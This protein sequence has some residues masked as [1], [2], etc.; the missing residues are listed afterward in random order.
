VAP[1]LAEL[2]Q[3]QADAVHLGDALAAQPRIGVAVLLR[4][5]DRLLMGLRRGPYGGGEWSVPSG[6]LERGETPVQCAERE[7][8]EEAGIAGVAMRMLRARPS[9]GCVDAVRYSYVSTYDG[10]HPTWPDFVTLWAVGALPEPAEARVLEPEKCEA[11][12]WVTRE[13]LPTP[14]FRCFASLLRAGV[15]PWCV[16]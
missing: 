15:D 12:R 13:E 16:E 10:G 7:L 6:K 14:L 3:A 4:A 1:L 5:G 11:W 8:R 2:A 9:A